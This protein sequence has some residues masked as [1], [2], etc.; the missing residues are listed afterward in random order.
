TAASTFTVGVTLQVGSVGAFR[1]ENAS[2]AAMK[3]VIGPVVGYVLAKALGATQMQTQVAV[4]LS[5]VPVGLFASFAASMFGL[6]RNLANSL[7][8]VNTAVYLAAVLPMLVWLLPF[9]R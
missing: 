3:F 7:F 6:N 4:I 9:I 5:S 2:M 8:V 1:S